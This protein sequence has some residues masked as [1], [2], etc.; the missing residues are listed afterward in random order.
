[1]LTKSNK[2]L[3]IDLTVVSRQDKSGNCL[4]DVNKL[5]E[6]SYLL[7]LHQFKEIKMDNISTQTRNQ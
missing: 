4:I 6:Q 5:T 7:C 2:T 3:S 1:M